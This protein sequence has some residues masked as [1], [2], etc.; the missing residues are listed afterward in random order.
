MTVEQLRYFFGWC[1]MFN[2][3]LL[4]FWFL[5]CISFR[6]LLLDLCRRFF[7]ISEE[8]YDKGMFYGIMFYKLGIIMLTVMPY[9]TLR[10]LK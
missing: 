3:G 1:A 2:Y 10:V 4:I 7:Q 8:T 6:G 9:F 5:C